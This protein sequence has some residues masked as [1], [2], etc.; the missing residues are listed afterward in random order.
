MYGYDDGIYWDCAVSYNI[1]VR[2]YPDS[3]N[4]LWKR[5]VCGDTQ[6]TRQKLCQSYDCVYGK[7]LEVNR[8]ASSMPDY[9]H[10]MLYRW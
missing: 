9:Q 5:F 7:L 10:F 8:Y 6:Y 1:D 4:V 3:S 2:V